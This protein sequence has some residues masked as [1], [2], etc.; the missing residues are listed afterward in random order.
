ML[1]HFLIYRD[2]F[3]FQRLQRLELDNI[4]NQG[5]RLLDH[6]TECE[7]LGAGDILV[8]KSRCGERQR[9]KADFGKQSVATDESR[10]VKVVSGQE[11]RSQGD[12]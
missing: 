3:K 1:D 4:N 2:M 11:W 7:R 8:A 12:E 10:G 5:Q 6:R 9:A